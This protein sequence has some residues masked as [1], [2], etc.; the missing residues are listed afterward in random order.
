MLK[1]HLLASINEG[2]QLS[3]H[4]DAIRQELKDHPKTI[5]ILDD[6]PTGTQTVYNVPVVTSWEDHVLERE[7][8][9]SPVFF[10]LTNS[11]SL[12]KNTTNRF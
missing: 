11:R 9:K 2:E 8:L 7:V 1:D 12:Q 3:G 10:I 6:D 4:L 5:V